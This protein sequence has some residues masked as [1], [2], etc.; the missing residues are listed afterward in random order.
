MLVERLRLAESNETDELQLASEVGKDER[1]NLLCQCKEREQ[2]V[3]KGWSNECARCR[4]G[5]LK[6]ES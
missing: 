5:E 4:K 1:R 2:V 3:D 6:V